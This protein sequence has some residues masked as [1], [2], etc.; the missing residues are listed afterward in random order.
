MKKSTTQFLFFCT[1]FLNSFLAISQNIISQNHD[2][3]IVLKEKAEIAFKILN[4]QKAVSQN[5]NTASNNQFFQLDETDSYQGRKSEFLSQI[6]PLE[7]PI[8]FPTYTKNLGVKG[9]NQLITK[10]YKLEPY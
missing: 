3:K 10:Y 1:L 7:L 9:Y 6:I 5:K 2:Q 8:D 4:N